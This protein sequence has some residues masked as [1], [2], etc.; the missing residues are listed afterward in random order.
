LTLEIAE[1]VGS[2]LAGLRRPQAERVPSDITFFNMLLFRDAHDYR[3]RPGDLDIIEGRTYDGTRILVP[4]FDIARVKP[5]DLLRLQGNEGWFYPLPAAAVA[6][7]DPAAVD[8]RTLRDDSDYLYESA[9]F[10]DYARVGLGAKRHAV[11]RLREQGAIETEELNFR[12]VPAAV[13]VLAGWCSDRGLA[14]DAADAKPCLEAL[15]WVAAPAA[16]S[17]LRG[18]IHTVKGAA[19]GFLITEELNPGVLAVRFA[20]GRVRHDGIYAYMFQE[21]ARR[22]DS[23][24]DFLNFEQDMGNPNFRRTKLSFRPHALLD[25]FR[26][27]IRGAQGR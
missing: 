1:R 26:L 12:T 4:L 7:F 5:S 14:A 19:A 13:Q 6:R 21:L 8:V 9:A 24:V 27:R 10:R 23:E 17:T 22:F 3:Y 16:G 15:I 2:T 11:E 18:W 25:K 20:K